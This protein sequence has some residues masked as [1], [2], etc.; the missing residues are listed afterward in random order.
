MMKNIA[1]K[2]QRH[3]QEIQD[4][5]SHKDNRLLIIAGPCSIHNV[6]EAYE[7][8]KLLK[9]E[10]DKYEDSLKIV[11]RTYFD[12]PRTTK[13]WEG[14]AYDPKLDGSYDTE[15]GIEITRKLL[16][17]IAELDL[18]TGAE[19]LNMDMADNFIHLLSYGAIGARNS[20]D[21]NLRKYASAQEIPM[22]LKHPRCGSLDD[23]ANTV[24]AATKSHKLYRS[25]TGTITTQGNPHAHMI[26]RGNRNG[27][28]LNLETVLKA[29]ELMI[30]KGIVN[31]SIIADLSHDNCLNE[32]GKDHRYQQQNLINCLELMTLH[33]QV[34]N[35]LRGVMIESN[36]VGGNQ[37]I[38]NGLNLEYGKS[39]TDPCI[40][41]QTTQKM[42][43]IASNYVAWQ[44][45]LKVQVA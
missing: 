1:E 26:L 40:D 12:K 23:G 30:K 4:I 28:N 17:K 43:E 19:T 21:Q 25:H 24:S 41:F 31:P 5:I 22:G 44:Q 29:Q 8:A 34:Q 9:Q 33:P 13:G 18:A 16:A 15:S 20:E 3:R 7:Y 32:N 37:A 10:Q 27:S 38:G 45:E 14:I 42:L 39:I 11:M 2:I 6:D 36:L 35:V